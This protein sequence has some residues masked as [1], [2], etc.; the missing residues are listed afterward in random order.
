M[1]NAEDELAVRNLVA[2]YAD[3]VNRRDPEGMAAIFVADGVI[4]KPGFGDPVCGVEKIT[5][6]Y[7]RLQRERDFLCQMINSGI[8]AIDRDTATA[9]WWFSEMKKPVGSDD[10]LFLIGVYQDEAVRTDHGWR[11]SRRVQTTI[12]EQ[13]IPGGTG[14]VASPLPPFFALRGLP[15]V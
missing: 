3:A 15:G 10:W 8:V 14:I 5:R 9:R 1:Q 7:R 2:A 6:R 13:T 11:I 12:M 4:E